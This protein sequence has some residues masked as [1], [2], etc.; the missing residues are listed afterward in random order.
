MGR[1]DA[2]IFDLD[3]TLLDTLDDLAAA[4][5]HALAA[6]GWPRRTTEEVRQFVGNGVKLL[7]DRAAPPDSG[8]ADRARALEIFKARYAEHMADRT[9]PYPGIPELLTALRARGIKTAVVSNKFDAAVKGLAEG[10]FPGLLSVAA[11]ELESAGI[12]KKPHP[13]MVEKVLAE[14]GAVRERAVYVGDSDVDIATARN[15][16]LACI[17]VTWGFRDEAFLRAHGAVDL[18][19]TPAEILRRVV[20]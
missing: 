5:D 9:A 1:Y 14:L 17:A 2:V 15:A 11:G 18:A 7:M 10:Y 3:G 12:P 8:E 19:G 16:G 13:A 20:D 4:V 6:M